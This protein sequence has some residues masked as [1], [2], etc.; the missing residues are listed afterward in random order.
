VSLAGRPPARPA[1][2]IL[3]GRPCPPAPEGWLSLRRRIFAPL[4]AL[5]AALLLAACGAASGS[6]G[7]DRSRTA[8]SQT[9]TSAT[10]TPM[11]PDLTVF[12]NF[13]YPIAGACL[14]SSD[15]LM[16]NASRDYRGGVHEG[17]DFYGSDNCTTIEKG[18]PVLAAKDGTVIRADH[19][20][21]PLTQEELDAA[22]AEIAAGHAN[23][24]KVLDLFRGRQVWVD[25]GHGIIT[26][27]AHLSAIPDTVRA[28][29]KVVQ[30]E[31]IGSVGDSGTPES[32]TAPD[33]ENHLH[34]EVRTGDTYL[35]AGL[36]P[37]DVRA[38]YEKL[39]EPLPSP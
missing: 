19:D 28:G 20:Y 12:R 14:P 18:T 3:H 30:G 23:D 31:T 2:A 36:P 13:I 4:P 10:A 37:D 8:A 34:W 21:H 39:F 38:I 27:Y 33:T 1:F 25:H 22:D 24:P 9:E 16:P 15:A 17:V 11:A 29:T 32:L 5:L 35:G 7:A 6:S 26:R